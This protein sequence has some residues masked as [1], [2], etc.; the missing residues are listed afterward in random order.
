RNVCD[1]LV[2]RLAIPRILCGANSDLPHVL[3]AHLSVRHD[4]SMIHEFVKFVC[5]ELNRLLLLG[6]G[7]FV[8]SLHGCSLYSLSITT[9][10]LRRPTGLDDTIRISL[11]K[12]SVFLSRKH[13]TPYPFLG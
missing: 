4:H 8:E 6:P 12:N 9:C 1:D 11:G 13:M 7:K 5:G 2:G 10:M 3:F